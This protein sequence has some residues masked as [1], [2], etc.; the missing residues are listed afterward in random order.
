MSEITAALVK[1]LRERTGAPMMKC[2]SFLTQTNG[3]IEE[4][5]IAMR[6][7]DPSAASKRDG[8]VA[9]EGRI[10]TASSS[11]HKKVAMVEVN[12]E[13]DFVGGGEDLKAFADR[14][15]QAALTANTTDISAIMALKDPSAQ[16]ETFDQVRLAM[17]AK[18][19]EKIELRRAEIVSSEGVLGLYLHGTRIGVLVCGKGSLDAM[20]DVAMH[21][22]ASKPVVVRPDEMPASLLASEKEIYLAQASDSGKDSAIMEKMVEGRIKKFVQ[23]N[24]LMGQPFVKSPDQTVEQYLKS[25]GSDVTSFVRLEVGEG[26]V[27][28]TENFADEVK[29]QLEAASEKK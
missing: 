13:T 24:C 25:V 22:A 20:K 12:C 10:A 28:K 7:A 4:A 15:A 9:A 26:I 23:A 17:I 27:K 18:I 2:K 16:G 3:N 1:E 21:I 14:L 8:K 29:A 6:K 19:G 11:D 5:I